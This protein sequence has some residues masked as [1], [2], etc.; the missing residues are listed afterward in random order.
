LPA[1]SGE[2]FQEQS[3]QSESYPSGSE[4]LFNSP[5]LAVPLALATMISSFFVRNS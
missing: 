3:P 2:G 5:P 1:A 4:S